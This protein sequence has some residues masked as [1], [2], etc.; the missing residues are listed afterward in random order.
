MLQSGIIP[1][2]EFQTTRIDFGSVG[3]EPEREAQ[4]VCAGATARLG[5]D[6]VGAT[7]MQCEM[8]IVPVTVMTMSGS[9][10][11]RT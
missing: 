9:V 7:T 2:E 11:M 1:T 8:G 4:I 10:H 5:I 6:P 3:F